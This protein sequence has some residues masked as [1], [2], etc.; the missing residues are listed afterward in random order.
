MTSIYIIWQV[1]H[2]LTVVPVSALPPMRPIPFIE[3]AH[4]RPIVGK[5]RFFASVELAAEWFLKIGGSST[6]NIDEIRRWVAKHCAQGAD[7]IWIQGNP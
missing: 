4:D 1:L 6:S 7:G 5:G 3:R 2:G